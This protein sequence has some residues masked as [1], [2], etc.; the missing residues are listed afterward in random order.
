LGPAPVDSV[1]SWNTVGQ[2]R[3]GVARAVSQ[4]RIRKQVYELTPEDLRESPVWEFCLDEEGKDGQ[5][6]ATVRPYRAHGPLDPRDGMFIVRAAFALADGSRASGYLTPPVQNSSGIGTL[7]PTIVTDAGQV[8]FWFGCAVPDRAIL[9][10]SYAYLGKDSGLAVFPLCFESQV[11]LIGG[12]ILGSLPGFL[13]CPDWRG[14]EG[15]VTT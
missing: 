15:I 9:A 4:M 8:V 7:Q 6:E 13:Y 1:G 2:A 10:K 14:E 3:I 12:P 5:D 11:E